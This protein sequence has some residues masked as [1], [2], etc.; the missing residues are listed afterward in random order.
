MDRF[1]GTISR[2]PNGTRLTLIWS[3]GLKINCTL[4]TVYETDNGLEIEEDGYQEY[5]ACA[6][7]VETV[8]QTPDSLKETVEVGKLIEVSTNSEPIKAL[9]EG[10]VVIWEK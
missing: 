5:Y 7:K 2:F 8:L 9:L 1:V 3:S 4:D 6:V 10:G